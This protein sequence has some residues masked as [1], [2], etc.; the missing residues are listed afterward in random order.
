MSV[1]EENGYKTRKEYLKSLAKEYG[2]SYMQVATIA[3]LLGPEE[4][5]DGL[6]SML[7]DLEEL[8]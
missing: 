2:L 3:S 8:V 4:D 5:F 6:I 7:E 1:Y